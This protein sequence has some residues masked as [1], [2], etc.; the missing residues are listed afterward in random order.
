MAQTLNEKQ[1]IFVEQYALNGGNGT[2][3]AIA[4][5][6]QPSTAAKTACVMLRMGKI[7]EY[8]QKL[9][10]AAET[11]LAA[12]TE[13]TIATLTEV[14]AYQTQIMQAST[15]DQRPD[16]VRNGLKAAAGLQSHYEGDK[17]KFSKTLNIN[18]PVLLQMLGEK[19]APGALGQAAKALL[20]AGSDD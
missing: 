1:R 16:V 4:A 14:L 12:S 15:P 8:L 11:R 18:G 10:A 6:Y 2:K 9:T 17:D 5:G 20:S 3:A 7:Q 19:I 13:K